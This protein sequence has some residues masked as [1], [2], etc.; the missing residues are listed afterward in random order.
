M[1]QLIGNIQSLIKAF[2][3]GN[4]NAAPSTLVQGAALQVEDLSPVLYNTTFEDKHIKLQKKLK[5]ET[6]KSTTAQFDR[7]LSY[8]QFGGSSTLEGGIGQE[9]TSSF[10]RVLVP[11]AFYSHIRRVTVISTMVATVD[12]VKSDERAAQDAAKKLGGD[13][14]FDCFRGMAD[15]SNAGVFD[16]NPLCLPMQWPGMHGLD[17]QVRQSDGQRNA[18][19]LMFAEYGSDDSVVI[20]GGGTLTQEMLE[21]ANV[22]SQMNFGEAD[23][24][25]VDPKVLANYNKQTYGKERII[26]AGS[27]QDAT[28]A[29]L[30]RQWV[31][32]GTVKIEASRFL[33][34]KAKP[35]SSRSTAPGAP[36][37][38]TPASV[39]DANAVTAFKLG[40]KYKYYAT[41]SNEKGESIR[42]AEA[43]VT[44]AVDGDTVQVSI[45]HPASGVW[46]FF[47]VY[48]TAAGGAA[49]TERYIGRIV[50]SA[51]AGPTVFIDLGN[52]LPG[53]VT[54]FLI[55]QD[56]MGMK[57]L[58]P[59][60]RLKLAI[61]DLTQ[62]EAYFRFCT[63]AVY[64]PRKN[65]LVDNLR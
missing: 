38:V 46:R 1:D 21:D 59:Y 13:I 51:G 65:V 55:Q 18:R 26:L 64:E 3:A 10:V 22:R 48:R 62:P 4:Y 29:D 63:L 16:G 20:S 32:G 14:E 33:S 39:T 60:S 23:N 34:G 52:K 41:A 35:A 54:G 8:G 28:G 2:E 37:S 42:C 27:P 50:T 6:C 53:F 19:D 24:L 44:I 12:G 17:V 58:A 45:A 5:A 25:L 15:F 49:G 9:E 57:E 31:S 36:V 7:Q 40:Q 61:T 11:M 43:E 56:T 30:A 47:N